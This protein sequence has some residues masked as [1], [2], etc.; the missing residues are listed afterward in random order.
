MCN[1]STLVKMGGSVVI[2]F[3]PPA[4]TGW[5]QIWINILL[6]FFLLLRCKK[7]LLH[8]LAVYLWISNEISVWN[9]FSKSLEMG[10]LSSSKSFPMC[11]ENLSTT[12]IIS[13]VPPFSKLQPD[14]STKYTDHIILYVIFV[15]AKIFGVIYHNWMWNEKID[16]GCSGVRDFQKCF[17][18]HMII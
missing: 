6:H 4:N 7:Y 15:A 13:V 5:S 2:I 16:A 14:Q 12:S 9:I 11:L 18:I 17:R 3:W 1:C 8:I 10:V